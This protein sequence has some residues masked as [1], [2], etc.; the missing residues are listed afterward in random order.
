MAHM[1]YMERCRGFMGVYRSEGRW[2]YR[3]I[4]D[5]GFRVG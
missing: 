3:S 4:L 5:L 2:W 1:G